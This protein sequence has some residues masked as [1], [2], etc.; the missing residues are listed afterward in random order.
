MQDMAF[1]IS[2]VYCRI[3][4]TEL[5]RLNVYKILLF[6]LALSASSAG[7]ADDLKQAG[8]KDIKH[9]LNAATEQNTAYQASLIGEANGKVYIV[10]ESLIHPGSSLS[11]K[12]RHDV[13]WIPAAQLSEEQLTQF[14]S[15]RSRNDRL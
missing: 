4:P 13:Y 5:M 15:A 11:R 1:G 2:F 6:L 9:L 14:H 10:Y 12:P 3:R 7:F 8:P